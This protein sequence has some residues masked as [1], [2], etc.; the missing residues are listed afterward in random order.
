MPD[1]DT[2][3]DPMDKA[4]VQAEAVLDDAAARAARRARVLA[5]VAA[6]PAAT[7]AA[8]EPL[9]PRRALGRGGWLIAAS[10]VGLSVLVAT[11][12]NPPSTIQGPGAV[13][14]LSTSTAPPPATAPTPSAPEAAPPPPAAAAETPA[15]P[16]KPLRV[17]LAGPAASSPSDL[18]AAPA[19]PP[20]PLALPPVAFLAPPAQPAPPPATARAVQAPLAQAPL[21]PT[22]L[23]ASPFARAPVAPFAKAGRAAPAPPSSVQEMIV[24]G[25][26]VAAPTAASRAALFAGSPADRAERLREAAG[27]GRIDEVEALLDRGVPVD[28]AD[29]DGETPLMKA[30]KAD[31]P[32]IVALLVSRHASLDR[33]NKAGRS[34]R[35]MAAA[36]GD[37][38]LK[39]A[40]GPRG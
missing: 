34:V 40:L 3:P 33:R 12:I 38:K 22:P 39:A 8:A 26:R 18:A 4:Y 17:G 11:R 25:S 28:G 32:E 36:A 35:D 21:S 16:S 24:T 31:E 29:D 1:R 13:Q 15:R 14:A 5:A 37:A 30:V 19:P 10:V 27:D 23:T 2:M 20:P 6:E 9:R 7:P